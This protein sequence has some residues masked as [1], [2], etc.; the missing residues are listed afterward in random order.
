MSIGE[1]QN[2]KELLLSNCCA[3]F[4][5][6]ICPVITGRLKNLTNLHLNNVKLPDLLI[7]V[8]PTLQELYFQCCQIDP[9]L[10]LMVAIRGLKYLKL[11]S[12]TE[13]TLSHTTIG[14]FYPFQVEST[15]IISLNVDH[16]SWTNMK[17]LLGPI[18]SLP[19]KKIEVCICSCDRCYSSYDSEEEKEEEDSDDD[20]EEII[21]V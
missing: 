10:S 17:P 2:L 16:E 8:L 6:S 1:L 18:L 15:F 13:C 19:R 5:Q 9:S 11:L 20:D 3:D 21:E 4:V 12:L 7:S 14:E